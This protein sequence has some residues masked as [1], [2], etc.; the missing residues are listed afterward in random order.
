MIN[1]GV[2]YGGMSTESEISQ[3]SA[4]AILDNLNKDKYNIFQIYISKNG[5]WYEEKNDERIIIQNIVE[6]LKKL[7][8]VF[9][10]LHGL[11]GE[12]GTIQG[13]LELFNIK[14][15]GCKV[16]SSSIAMDK[17]YA[18]IIFEKA[19]INQT[20]YIYIK[21]Y[22]KGKN[23]FIDDDF[24]EKEVTDDE[25]AKIIEKRLKYPMYIKPS[26]S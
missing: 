12:D 4:K 21:K 5:N 22:E 16:L 1:L 9:P 20:K 18:K 17:A 6:Y 15:I 25:L 14:Y 7:D 10:V 24:C 26:N 2:I 3:K 23:I 19:K 8:I 11:Y 13:M